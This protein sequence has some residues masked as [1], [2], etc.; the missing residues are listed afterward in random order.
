M[1]LSP[2]M[3]KPN[4]I[5]QINPGIFVER[6]EGLSYRTFLQSYSETLA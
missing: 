5:S 3:E 2:D 6:K 4:S 1:T